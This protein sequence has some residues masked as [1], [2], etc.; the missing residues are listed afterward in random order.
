M[1]SSAPVLRGVLS[2]FAL[3][4]L[5]T[6]AWTADERVV[7]CATAVVTIEA[8]FVR[9]ALALAPVLC[10]DADQFNDR[11]ARLVAATN[12]AAARFNARYAE[13]GCDPD[14]A[15]PLAA[16]NATHVV[17]AL[18][19]VLGAAAVDRLCN[20]AADNDRG[21]S[22]GNDRAGPGE[23]CDGLDLNG[24]TCSSLGNGEGALGCAHDCRSFDFT[25]CTGAPFCGNGRR[26][27]NED[28]DDVGPSFFC[29]WDCTAR[30][31]GDR[32]I[33]EVAGEECD[34]GN[35]ANGD[36]CSA[37]CTREGCAAGG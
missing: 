12:E 15:L 25:G 18:Q 1:M 3:L 2:S 5:A 8:E 31:C 17:L 32:I 37:S 9:G 7:E 27:L 26:E 10:K 24:Q 21:G 29:D 6:P 20:G 16:R 11:A 19:R 14:L 34:D 4:V 36:G 28:C 13:G 35:F 33:N 22:C 30:S 23:V